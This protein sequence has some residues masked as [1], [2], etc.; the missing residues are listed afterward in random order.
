MGDSSAEESGWTFYLEDLLNTE[1][2]DHENN[3]MQLPSACDDEMGSQ[4]LCLVSD[5]ASSASVMGSSKILSS[6]KRRTCIFSKRSSMAS[7]DSLE[8]T[9]SSPVSSPKECTSTSSTGLKRRGLCLVPV[10]TIVNF[11][12]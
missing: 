6:K 1:Q 5:A 10:S 9:A 4:S 3:S 11:L 2:F 8:D 12:G 7:D